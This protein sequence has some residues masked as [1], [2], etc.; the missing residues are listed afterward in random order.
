VPKPIE[1]AFKD[2]IVPLNSGTCSRVRLWDAVYL[3][4]ENAPPRKIETR[5]IQSV[6]MFV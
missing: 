5:E 2:I 4:P 1:A 6:S 3:I